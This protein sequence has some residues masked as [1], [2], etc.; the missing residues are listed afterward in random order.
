L[1]TLQACSTRL[2]SYRI[3][4][5]EEEGGGLIA[6]LQGTVYRTRAG[7]TQD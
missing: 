1:R 7:I 3:E 4:V 5:V 2:A 6:Q